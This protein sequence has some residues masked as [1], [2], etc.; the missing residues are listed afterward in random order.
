MPK[1]DRPDELGAYQPADYTDKSR[2]DAIGRQA[3][4]HKL[5]MKNPQSSHCAQRHEHAERRHFEV[6]EPEQDRVHPAAAYWR[7]DCAKSIANFRIGRLVCPSAA[8]SATA[9]STSHRST[10]SRLISHI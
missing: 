7:R 4:A 10:A 1:F 3:A 2:I 9:R 8:A 5:T 6:A